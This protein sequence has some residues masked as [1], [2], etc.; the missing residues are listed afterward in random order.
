[1]RLA[2]WA[3][4]DLFTSTLAPEGVASGAGRRPATAG[5]AG[6]LY[7]WSKRALHRHP[8]PAQNPLTWRA[9]IRA[10]RMGDQ[11]VGAPFA[12][13]FAGAV[14]LCGGCLH[15]VV[16]LGFA[17]IAKSRGGPGRILCVFIF[18]AV[19]Q[20]ALVAAGVLRMP[21]I[22][23]FPFLGVV[24]AMGYELSKD[25]LRA[26][27]VSRELRESEQRM[28]LATEAANLGI[29][30]RVL[31]RNEI[32]ASDTWRELFGFTKSE[33]LDLDCFLQTDASRRSGSNSSGV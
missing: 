1:M 14:C 28:A 5:G 15:P 29:W 10:R 20:S 33:R 19:G 17:G 13:S 6:E 23:S 7:H 2:S 3:H 31:P 24:L 12:V 25:V 21:F 18:F 27:H 9:S 11:S 32:W 16:A 26:A 8:Q 22:V 30:I 4:W